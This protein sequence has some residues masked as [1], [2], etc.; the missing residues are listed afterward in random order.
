MPLT[1]REEIDLALEI[2]GRFRG[3]TGLDWSSVETV[4]NAVEPMLRSIPTEAE[5]R[6]ATDTLQ[7]ATA[8]LEEAREALH[9]A[10]KYL[11]RQ[12]EATALLGQEEVS[13][14]PLSKKVNEARERVTRLLKPIAPRWECRCGNAN[15]PAYKDRCETC[16]A[17]KVEGCAEVYERD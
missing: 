5:R 10:W 1:E 15:I 8:V 16:R 11:W 12:D 4:F 3:G 14:S 17:P 9:E 13:Y 7:E 6:A 2:I